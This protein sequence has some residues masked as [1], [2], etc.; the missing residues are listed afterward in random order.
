MVKK[1]KKS[2]IGMSVLLLVVIAVVATLFIRYHHNSKTSQNLA[3]TA[4]KSGAKASTSKPQALSVPTN[5][6]STPGGVVDKNGQAS[7]TLPPSS[8]W[9]ASASG[10]ITLQQPSPNTTIKN[11]D[12]ISGIAKVSTVNFILSD[13]SVGLI[14]RGSLNVVNGK[15]SGLMKFQSHSSSGKLEVYYPNPTNGREEDV[16]EIHVSFSP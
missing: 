4:S 3:G 7:G 13:N 15:F 8:D 12:T 10:N 1:R 9:V 14:D 2:P 5:Q 6:N 16:I 11:D